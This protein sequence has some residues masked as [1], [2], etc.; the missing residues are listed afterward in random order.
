[1]SMLDPSLPE[2]RNQLP[3]A[4]STH[5]GSRLRILALFLAAL[6]P[7][8]WLAYSWRT[9][10]QLG[11]Y[12]DDTINWVSAKSLAEGHGY[13]IPSLPQQPFQTKSPPVFP[14]L[15]ALV[16]KIN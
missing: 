3:S 7:S 5:V 15:L 13:R 2:L 4:D 6:A 16:W 9:M 14:A 10:P 11:F 1:M 12:H 8:A